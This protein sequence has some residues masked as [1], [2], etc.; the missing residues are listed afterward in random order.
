MTRTVPIAA[1]A[2][3]FRPGERV[4]LPGCAGEPV[5]LRAEWARDPGLTRGLDIVTSAIPGVNR[6]APDALHPSA[7]MTGL[8]MQP[9]LA[10]A[11]RAGRYRHL[12]I[13]YA[14]FVGHLRERAAFDTCVV[15]V[16]PPGPDGLCSLG[17]CVE[18]IP[19]AL[20][21]S[22]R[23]V[24]LIN[25]AMPSVAG[26]PALR[27][28]R[29]ELAAE[30]ET[31]L[32]TYDVGAPS[33]EAGA[34]AALVAGF[35]EDGAAVQVGLGKVPDLLF[36][37]LHDRR[38]LRLASG[39]LSDGTLPLAAA[40]A[41]DP[42]FRHA[43]CVWIGTTTLYG[44]LRGLDGRFALEGCEVTHDVCRLAALDRFVAVNSALG[45]DLFGQANLEH[46]EGRAV[47]GVG[48]AADFA[49][50]ARLSRGGVS[51]VALPATFGREPRSRIVPR[52]GEGVASLPRH[53]VDVVVTEHGAADLRGL[54]VHERAEA[55]IAIAAPPFRGDL[56]TA[57]AEIR[58]RT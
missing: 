54:S 10:A 45:I 1:L 22:R 23:A 26:A 42:G 56:T 57:W 29:F 32:P 51:I 49:A 21:R 16:A 38:G 25:P 35:V 40:G 24:A 4:F 27:L 43:T 12:P 5:A 28:D 6:P 50:A 8:F 11:Q 20:S 46:A 44:R 13:G 52:L 3:A 9:G 48:G 17:P 58:Q 47:S 55:L 14:G 34:I 2:A 41:L 36:G 33:P 7:R 19:L 31:P 53:A 30:V 18:F 37:L 39:M 15:Q